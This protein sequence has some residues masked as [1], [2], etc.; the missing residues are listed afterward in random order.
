[1][2]KLVIVILTVFLLAGCGSRQTFETVDD[3]PAEPAAAPMQELFLAYPEEAATPAMDNGQGGK[4]YLCDGYTLIVQTMEAGNLDRT[5]REITG[6]SKEELTLVETLHYGVKRY[7]C[8]WST[9]GEGGDQICR[10]AILDDG[11]HHYTVTV[12]APAETAGALGDTWQKLL[13]SVSLVSID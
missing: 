10:G 8:A 5:L 4:L 13:D 1:M 7:D 11:H 9:A 3:M 12:M 2:K 6:F